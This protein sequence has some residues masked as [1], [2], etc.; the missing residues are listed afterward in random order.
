[1]YLFF[2]LFFFAERLQAA[3]AEGQGEMVGG[4]PPVREGVPGEEPQEAASRWASALPSIPPRRGSHQATSSRP[5]G[6]GLLKIKK[7]SVRDPWYFSTDADPDPRIRTSDWSGCGIREAQTHTDPDADS[8]LRYIY[9][10][11]Q[12]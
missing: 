5:L 2:V 11:L 10:I 6:Q 1:M 9:V 3:H 4:L 12:R 7:I 8:E